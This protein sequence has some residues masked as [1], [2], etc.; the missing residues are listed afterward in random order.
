M[1]MLKRWKK[2]ST[3]SFSE[4]RYMMFFGIATGIFLL[5]HI[6]IWTFFTSKF[7][8]ANPYYIG[9]LGRM[10][11]QIDSLFPRLEQ[12][13]LPSKHI[14][15]NNWQN[16]PIDLITLGD[17]FSNGMASGKNAYY[18]DFLATSLQINVLN[19]QNIDPSFGYIDT[20]RYL[21]NNK[22]LAKVQPK[23]ILIQCVVRE[24]LNHVP[25][26]Q[27]ATFSTPEKLNYFL[28]KT[29]FTKEFPYTMLI[30]TGNYKAPYYYIKYTHSI[31]AKKEIY[32]FPL[33][34]NYFT[35]KDTNHLLV[36]HDDINK[37]NSFTEESI[38]QL[39]NE[40]NTIANELKQNN[41]TLIFMPVVDKYDFYYD[42]IQGNNAYPQ[43]PF[44]ILLR[45]QPKSYLL[46]DTK[47]ILHPLIEKNLQD[48][49]Y[50][51]DTHWS[52]KASKQIAD[53]QTFTFL[54]KGPK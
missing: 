35:S 20:I 53:D 12:N 54:K 17:S 41:I 11:Y 3:T 27:N 4:K 7:F 38:A 6:L 22:W 19:I 28:F 30:N 16:Q 44:F 49:Y 36:Y 25:T 21:H 46:V 26:K 40:L 18:Q 2:F 29:N 31:H 34:K 9:D 47:A 15:E 43:N 37:I 1:S 13:D 50:A 32:K 24:S 45:K 48:I 14:D 10:S 42:Y 39:N 23:A 33:I 52:F 51:D 8:N 5:Y